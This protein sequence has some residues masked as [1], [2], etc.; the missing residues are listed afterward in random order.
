MYSKVIQ[1]RIYINIYIIFY[2]LFHY[3][4]SQDIEYI[5]LWHT[6]GPWLSNLNPFFLYLHFKLMV[7]K[8][9]VHL[10]LE[11]YRD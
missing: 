2:I 3:R 11:Q 7:F 8:I 10:T 9:D 6:V 1:L 5:F 4:L